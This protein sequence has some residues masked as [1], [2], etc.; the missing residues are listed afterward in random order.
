MKLS[1]LLFLQ[2]I[3]FTQCSQIYNK[4]PIFDYSNAGYLSYF[5]LPFKLSTAL[6][7]NEFLS[8]QVSFN[9][10]SQLINTP[11]EYSIKNFFTPANLNISLSIYP[12]DCVMPTS[13][14]PIYAYTKSVD[15]TQY[16][17]RFLDINKNF[18]G[19]NQD[20]WYILWVNITDSN[21]LRTQESNKLLQIQMSTVSS[22]VENYITYDT[23]PVITIW[24]LL[25]APDNT[26]ETA[27]FF[28]DTKLQSAL[29]AN[30]LVYI[31]NLFDKMMF[32]YKFR[33]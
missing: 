8:L 30:N 13:K 27:I 17:L 21:V 4:D 29:T 22:T 1:L 28:A 20:S 12:N 19:L 18:V 6:S 11:E 5:G 9:L 7:S 25:D 31:G 15:S 26:L 23:N 14:T 3:L 10:H 33:Y 32:K 24:Q 2:I 16:F